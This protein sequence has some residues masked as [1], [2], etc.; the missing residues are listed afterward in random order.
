MKRV[1]LH[2]LRNVQSL[3]GVVANAAS[4]ERLESCKKK[5]NETDTSIEDAT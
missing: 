1:V 3:D 2:P 5:R 4:V